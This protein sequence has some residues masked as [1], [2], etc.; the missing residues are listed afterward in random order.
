MVK[1][2]NPD[3]YYH[4]FYFVGRIQGQKY[5]EINLSV[6]FV[7]YILPTSIVKTTTRLRTKNVINY[8][9]CL[10]NICYFCLK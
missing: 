4:P 5:K 6:V 3:A 2:F 1:M 10:K 9:F 8:T 7:T